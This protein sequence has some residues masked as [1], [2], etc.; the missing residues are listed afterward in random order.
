MILK[1]FDSIWTQKLIVITHGITFGP[2]V[3]CRFLI[4]NYLIQIYIRYSIETT[5]NANA[6]I[7][8]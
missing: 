4:L 6:F 2:V 1:L 5:L 3:N 7:F 8:G